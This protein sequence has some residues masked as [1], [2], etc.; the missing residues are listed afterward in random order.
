M[1]DSLIGWRKFRTVEPLLNAPLYLKRKVM[2]HI[3]SEEEAHVLAHDLIK[4]GHRVTVPDCQRQVAD[5][6]SGLQLH[7]SDEEYVLTICEKLSGISG[8]IDVRDVE[9]PL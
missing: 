2:F 4:M 5:I 6:I 3:L 8:Q 7:G 9:G 1:G